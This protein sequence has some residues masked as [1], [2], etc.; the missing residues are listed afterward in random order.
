MKKKSYKTISWLFDNSK[1]AL[2]RIIVL[3]VCAVAVS[4]IGV[5]F[6]LVSKELLDLAVGGGSIWEAVRSLAGLVVC[7]LFLQIAYT[8]IHLHTETELKNRLQRKIFRTLLGKKWQELSKFHSGE[9]MNRLNSDTGIVTTNV[10]SLVPNIFAFASRIVLGFSALYVLDR[11]FA[12]VFVIIGPFVMIVARLYS[13]FVKPLHKE[14]LQK[15]GKTHSFMLEALQN[16]LVV[17][18]FGVYERIAKM[19]EHFQKDHLRSIMKRGYI[20]IFANILFFISL[21]IGY[22]FAVAWCAYKISAGVMTVGTFTA[23]IQLVGQVQTPFKELASVVPQ[24]YAMTASAERLIELEDIPDE[25]KRYQNPDY[26]HIYNKMQSICVNDVSFAYDNEEILNGASVKVAKN[27]LTTISGISGIGKS[28][29]MKLML[30]IL[31]PSGG[32]VTF[33]CSG[34]EVYEA[35]ASLRPLF[36]YVPQG[37]MVLSGTVRENISFMNDSVTDSEIIA[38]A[39]TAC[40]YDVIAELPD[41][42]ATVLGE[43]G[44]GLSEGQLQRLAVAR[45]ICSG[46]PILLLDEATSALD[47]A[48]EH[49]MLTNIRNLKDRT[50]I[51]ISHKECAVRLSDSVIAIENGKIAQNPAL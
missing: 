20:S 18:S 42:F 25:Q 4:Y 8:L 33:E 28:T 10:M 44:S 46:A 37:N 34:G 24:A 38:A 2:W 17:K 1:F 49:E 9:L 16:V 5:R 23:I 50:C 32:S 3:T 7:Q 6:A 21:T 22:Y 27:S 36:A 12:L 35:D 30:G 47:E 14:C 15:Q 39:K 31:E 26:L 11:S 19:T 51:I 48:T 45:A 29:L 40:I 13:K 43:G 41:G